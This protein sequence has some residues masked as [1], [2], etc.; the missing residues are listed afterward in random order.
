MDRVA[1]PPASHPGAGTARTHTDGCAQRPEG[2][3]EH[4]EHTLLREEPD[5]DGHILCDSRFQEMRRAGS[6]RD[7]KR[8]SV[9][10][11]RGAVG[12]GRGS[13]RKRVSVAGSGGVVGT[14]RVSERK[15]VPGSR[16]VG[17]E[18]ERE[19]G[20]VQRGPG[21]GRVVLTGPGLPWGVKSP[22]ISWD[23]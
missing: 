11:S 20:Q 15:S 22:G 5:A 1:A 4:R 18:I 3:W 21:A 6:A 10:G 17:T 8:A 12:T 2:A 13:E 23:G 16:G 14:G 7:R 9:A 19:S